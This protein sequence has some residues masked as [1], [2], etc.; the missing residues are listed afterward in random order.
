MYYIIY[1]AL[2]DKYLSLILDPDSFGGDSD[3][4]YKWVDYVDD[5]I[6]IMSDDE[7]DALLDGSIDYEKGYLV[8]L[9]HTISGNVLG[10]DGYYILPIENGVADP[11]RSV[12]LLDR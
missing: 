10:M 9:Y 11:V 8:A 6:W 1:D 3:G 7:I 2:H 5:T 4:Y 12:R